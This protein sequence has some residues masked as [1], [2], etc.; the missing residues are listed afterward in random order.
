MAINWS[1][2]VDIVNNLQFCIAQVNF[3]TGMMM[4]LLEGELGDVLHL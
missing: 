1:H 2:S 4:L 3:K